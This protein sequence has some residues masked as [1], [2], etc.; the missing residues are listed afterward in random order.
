MVFAFAAVSS[1]NAQTISLSVGNGTINKGSTKRAYVVMEIPKGLH[2]NSNRPKSEYAIPTRVTV[3]A[4]GVTIGAVSYPPGKM[5]R[6]SFSDEPIS[7]YEGRVV[8][9]FN[10]TVPRG[11]RGRTFRLKADVRFQPCTDEVCYPP[12][13]KTVELTVRV[14]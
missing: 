3:E 4:S 14:R 6:F 11:F 8:F 5:K 9:G 12:R 10:V 7:I 1:V 2:V 13:T